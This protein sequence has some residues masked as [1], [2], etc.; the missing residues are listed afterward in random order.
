MPKYTV[1]IV[2][3]VQDVYVV[4]ARSATEAG[5]VAATRIA[6]GDPPDS[7]KEQGRKVL[8]AKTLADDPAE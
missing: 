5:M 7:S 6:N 8:S 4:E 3:T 2:R 1:P